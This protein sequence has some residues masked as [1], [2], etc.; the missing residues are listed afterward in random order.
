MTIARPIRPAPRDH[1]RIVHA[2][3]VR[4]LMT[5]YGRRN[6][7]FLWHVA[8]PLVLILGIVLVWSVVKSGTT[9]DVPVVPFALTGYAMLTLWRHQVTRC[10]TCARDDAPL[11]VHRQ[12]G[13]VHLLSARGLLELLGT[14]L[15]LTIAYLALLILELCPPIADPLTAIAAFLI[16]GLFAFGT[17]LLLAAATMVAEPMER[18]V[19]AFLYLALPLSGAFTLADWIAEPARSALLLSPLVHATEMF[20]SGFMGPAHA[21]H[22][23]LGYLSASTAT[24]LLGGSA[25]LMAARRHEASR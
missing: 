17:G 20:R 10:L 23:D 3:L 2:L 1:A 18:L 24:V 8:E 25:A 22:F 13:L 14:L 21:Y 5:R 7:G 11:L 4:D 15:A 19:P 6:I 16:M 12:V 9:H